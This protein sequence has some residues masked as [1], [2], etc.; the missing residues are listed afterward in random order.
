MDEYLEESQKTVAAITELIDDM[1]PYRK[2]R[3]GLIADNI[4]SQVSMHGEDGLLALTLVGAELQLA[5]AKSERE[6]SQ[7]PMEETP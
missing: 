6:E 5:A 7:E 3:V 1:P 2:M 4:R